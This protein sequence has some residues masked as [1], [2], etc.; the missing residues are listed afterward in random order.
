M[1]K[2]SFDYGKAAGFISQEE[3][4]YMTKLTE[5]A[6]ELLVS[7]TG[8]GNDFL[9]CVCLG[10]MVFWAPTT[11]LSGSAVHSIHCV[12]PGLRPALLHSYHYPWYL[13]QVTIISKMLE[14]LDASGLLLH[15]QPLLSS[16]G[17]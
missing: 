15:Q 8:A 2:V 16:H 14:P 1:E 7:K 10:A 17:L 13:S 3:V 6:R 12:S 5:D 9:G 11:L 4:T